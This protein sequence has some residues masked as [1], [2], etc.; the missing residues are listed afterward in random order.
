MNVKFSIFVVLLFVVLTPGILLR[1]PPKG[2][3][4]TV[5]I[6]HGV[7]FAFVLCMAHM[8]AS[9][10]LEGASNMGPMPSSKKHPMMMKK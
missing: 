8:Y 2:D 10:Y 4:F 5:A 9:T 1:L 3:K 6:V 7:V